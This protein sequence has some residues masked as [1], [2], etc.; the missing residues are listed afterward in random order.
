MCTM[1]FITRLVQIFTRRR[2]EDLYQTPCC[3]I[4]PHA[5]SSA[6]QPGGIVWP[7]VETYHSLLFVS[8]KPRIRDPRSHEGSLCDL[9]VPQPRQ[10]VPSPSCS[11]LVSACSTRL[12]NLF[13]LS[14]ATDTVLSL[15]P[16]FARQPRSRGPAILH[17]APPR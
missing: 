3:C 1:K 15:S 10:N 5:R 2:N 13:G 9:I 16:G 12:I 7:S 4:I 14:F 6:K 11:S 17:G 8:A